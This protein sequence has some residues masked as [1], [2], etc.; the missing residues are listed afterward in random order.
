MKVKGNQSRPKT[1]YRKLIKTK[2]VLLIC[3]AIVL[4]GFISSSNLTKKIT[5]KFFQ[6]NYS[7]IGYGRYGSDNSFKSI[8]RFFLDGNP[9]NHSKLE[10]IKIDVKYENW[11]KITKKRSES[12]S[13][14]LIVQNEDDY[15]PA[16]I[17]FRGEDFKADIRL[18]GDMVDH[19]K[20]DKW[21]FRIKTKGN[22]N[23]L[24][25]KKFNLQHPMTRGYHTQ[26]VINKVF[27]D[28]NLIVQ[29][30]DLV[31][32]TING[33]DIGIMLIEEHFSKELLERNK[34]KDGVI[35]K[36]DETNLWKSLLLNNGNQ[37]LYKTDVNPFHSPFTSGLDVYSKSKVI[38]DD[39]LS[40]QYEIAISLL[41][42]FRRGELKASEAFDSDLMGS[43][44]G[45]LSFFKAG[46]DSIWTNLR[47]YL[48]PYTLK[49]EPIPSEANVGYEINPL[50]EILIQQILNDNKIRIAFY[51]TLKELNLKY[52][53]TD[54][55]DSLLR[56]E[57]P[58]LKELKKEFFFLETMNLN[59]LG[60]CLPMSSLNHP[61]LIDSKLIMKGNKYMLEV[62]NISCKNILIKSITEIEKSEKFV[63]PNPI[64]LE[65]FIGGEV[66][67]SK[68]INLNDL[69]FT[70][71]D[72][73]KF[74]IEVHDVD[75]ELMVDHFS[76]KYP[77]HFSS[78]PFIKPDI[79]ELQMSHSFISIDGKNIN[80]A[81]GE[82]DVDGYIAIPCDHTVIIN[83][84]TTL[85]FDIDGFIYSC[86]PVL[87]NGSST[88]KVIFRPKKDVNSWKG[89]AIYNANKKS[90]INHLLVEKTSEFKIPFINLT[91]GVT[92]YKSNVE[93]RDSMFVDS[94]G[95]DALN[96]IH[97]DMHLENITIANT[98]SDA[99][100]GDFVTGSV[101]NSNF[102]N[103]GYGGGGDAVDV[104]GS[105]IS[106]NGGEFLNIDDK[107]I[108]IGEA[109]NAQ[110]QNILVKNSG[111]AIASKDAS[112]VNATNLDLDNS[113]KYLFMSYMK[114]PVYG[115]AQIIIQDFKFDK[116]QN[117]F[118]AQTGS[119][120]IINNE[121]IN[122]IE[123]DV[124]SLYGR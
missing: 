13:A 73:S 92:F 41:D 70:V 43:Y 95:E 120:L 33:D 88:N 93:I 1:I 32:V 25:L 51:N 87:I 119:S 15:V 45:I 74:S 121:R 89:M 44:L 46:H 24:G 61:A 75:G 69:G 26:F 90:L 123:I 122:E 31:K 102:Y 94:F 82:Y 86:S 105:K 49:L 110:I 27:K 3:V 112:I 101:V 42:G 10:V 64:F 98:F 115:G 37:T 50:S 21:S 7:D 68:I 52:L 2:Y 22:S 77:E 97:S 57:E 5:Q 56:T 23:L 91:G 63:L 36:F 39:Y 6:L 83:N 53:K 29:K 47:L 67:T 12:I 72:A 34:R 103:I 58:Y 14:G 107:A 4:L 116:S 59:F 99:F 55:L 106:I 80:F 8:F 124:D 18:K 84:G 109:S 60:S 71:D 9:D 11:S 40:S 65:P 81:K 78:S 54:N 30:H 104:S 66:L 28:Y 19:L 85:N 20:D 79:S 100:D 38:K 76:S 111:I 48:N 62:S 16:K 114:K 17:T 96:I 113:N 118:A 108:S 35:I 117:N